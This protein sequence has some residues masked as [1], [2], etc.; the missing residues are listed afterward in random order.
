MNEADAPDNY[1]L[2][3]RIPGVVFSRIALRLKA[4]VSGVRFLNASSSLLVN[5]RNTGEDEGVFIVVLLEKGFEQARKIRLK[6][7][8]NAWVRFPVYAPEGGEVVVKVF[9]GREQLGEDK[10][11]IETEE[12]LILPVSILRATGLI[13]MILGAFAILMHLHG[14]P[15]EHPPVAEEAPPP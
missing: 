2:T 6:P 12:S 15:K 14:E 7:G 11:I 13:L 8:E 3:L 10:V 1:V 4:E 5:I 9:G